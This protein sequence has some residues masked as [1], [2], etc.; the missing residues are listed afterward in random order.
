M[1]FEIIF[2]AIG[3]IVIGLVLVK[4]KTTYDMKKIAVQA[5]DKIEKQSVQ[6]IKTVIQEGK[7]IQL[8]SKKGVVNIEEVPLKKKEI[9]KPIKKGKKPKRKNDK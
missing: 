7:K 4:L 8:T 2:S 6:G 1:I 9:K 5:V 3:A